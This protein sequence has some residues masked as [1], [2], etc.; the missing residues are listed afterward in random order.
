MNK[1]ACKHVFIRVGKTNL[2]KCRCGKVRYKDY[3]K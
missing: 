2:E 3:G 1:T